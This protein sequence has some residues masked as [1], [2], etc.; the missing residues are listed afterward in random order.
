MAQTEHIHLES[1]SREIPNARAPKSVQARAQFRSR[2]RRRVLQLDLIEFYYLSVRSSTFPFEYVIDLRHIDGVRRSR[3][4]AWR[5]LGGSLALG[6]LLFLLATKVNLSGFAWWQQNRLWVW[7]SLVT[8]W[9]VVTFVGIYRTTETWNLFSIIG[10]VGF[11]EFTTGLGS[12]HSHRAFL[13]KLAAHIQLA[14]RDRRRTKAEHLRDETREHRR[15]KEIGVLSD[16]E[17]E[18]A[19]QRILDQHEGAPKASVSRAARS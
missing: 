10:R 14:E 4:I 17:Y 8:V 2:L 3:H 15:L 5:W 19:K 18:V 7:A 1:D 6:A 12:F 16:E 13:A 11:L 9:A